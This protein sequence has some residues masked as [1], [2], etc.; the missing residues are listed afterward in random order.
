MNEEVV[1]Y[2]VDSLI[3][4]FP[5][6][7]LRSSQEKIDLI[8]KNNPWVLPPEINS[9]GYRSEE[10]TDAHS[11]LHIVFSGDS[12]TFGT[13]V[14]YEEC[15]AKLT[16]NKLNKDFKC[17]G[18]FNLGYPGSCIANQVVDLFKYF[19]QYGNPKA[20]FF[21]LTNPS[22]FYMARK[23]GKL[24]NLTFSK[25][26]I[27]LDEEDGSDLIQ[28]L[29]MQ[30]YF[31]LQEYCRQSGIQLYSFSWQP[32][33]SFKTMPL[34]DSFYTWSE[35]EMLSYIDKY[36]RDNHDEFIEIARD[37]NHLGTAAHS[38]WSDFIYKKFKGLV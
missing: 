6:G 27:S 14:L 35:Y 13:G 2:D 31:M 23:D 38:F 12:Y 22:R 8:L 18:Y 15:W 36:S 20:I 10:F 4:K 16:Y 1:P 9:L 5:A 21:N 11:G 29:S 25:D 26:L 28:T 32:N 37:G 17:S 3:G 33:H 7:K 24:F 30:Y 34:I 19:K